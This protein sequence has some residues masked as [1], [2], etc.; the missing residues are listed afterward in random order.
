MTAHGAE[1]FAQKWG[2]ELWGLSSPPTAAELTEALRQHVDDVVD[3]AIS[4]KQAAGFFHELELSPPPVATRIAAVR[5]CLELAVDT[6]MSAQRAEEFSKEHGLPL[7]LSVEAA[8]LAAEAAAVE[9][10]ETAHEGGGSGSDAAAGSR[11]EEGTADGEREQ[12]RAHRLQLTS[13]P[14]PPLP[15]TSSLH[16]RGPMTAM[17]RVPTA[18]W[19]RRRRSSTRDGTSGR[20]TS[21]IPTYRTASAPYTTMVAA[22]WTSESGTG[23]RWWARAC[24]GTV[25]GQ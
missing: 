1:A 22:S 17:G 7:P 4:E 9:K 11:S 14:R 23:K 6:E 12:G 20:W 18:R 19:S 21:S 15:P 2:G 13:P 3:G 16:R 8:K 5:E 10:D 24:A 25:I